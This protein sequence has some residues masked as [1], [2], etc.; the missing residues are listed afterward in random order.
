M[1]LCAADWTPE[2]SAQ[3]WARELREIAAGT[4]SHECLYVAVDEGGELIGLAMGGPAGADELLGGGG[5]FAPYFGSHLHC[6][7]PG[8]RYCRS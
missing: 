5:Y 6:R 8:R 2:V 1:Y 4:G 3:A 7:G